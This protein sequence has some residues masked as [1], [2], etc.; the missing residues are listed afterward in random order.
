MFDV[1]KTGM[2]GLPYSEKNYD[3]PFSY[4]TS[5]LRTDTDR[6]TDRRTDGQT[7]GQN[8]YINIVRQ[9][10]ARAI[11]IVIIINFSFLNPRKLLSAFIKRI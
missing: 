2:I 8:C 10:A 1:G 4:N 9:C 7:D 6:Q 3:N 5:V 11:K